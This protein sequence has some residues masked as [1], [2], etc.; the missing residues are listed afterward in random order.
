MLSKR[1]DGVIG[2]DLPDIGLIKEFEIPNLPWDAVDGSAST[3]VA[4]APADLDQGVLSALERYLGEDGLK[5]AAHVAALAI[6][7]LYMVMSADGY[8]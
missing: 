5:P 4:A 8:R 2:V 7:Y 3:A 1:A 6:L